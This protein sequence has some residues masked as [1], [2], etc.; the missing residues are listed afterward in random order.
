M[1][2]A[3]DVL[4]SKNFETTRKMNKFTM[5]RYKAIVKYKT[6]YYS[7]QLPVSLAMF[8]AGISDEKRHRQAKLILLEMGSYFQIQD[9]YLDCFGNM[10]EIGK[11]GTDIQDGKCTWLLVVALQRANAQQ[12]EK[13]DECYGCNDLEKVEI[14]KNI[15]KEIG[16]PNIY[17]AFEEDTYNLLVTRIQQISRGL[18]HDVFFLNFR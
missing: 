6:A 9:D 16:L 8:M 15:Y 2:Q 1:G 7:F 18:P 12:K 4:L 13:L 17:A 14:V 3:L 10:A 11:S 5:D